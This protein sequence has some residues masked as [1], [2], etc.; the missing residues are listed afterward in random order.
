MAREVGLPVLDLAEAF[1]GQTTAEMWVHS[2]DHHPNGRAHAIASAA[3]SNWLQSND[4][5][6]LQLS[7][8][9]KP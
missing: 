5:E 4:S 9:G 2:C 7:V 3:I 6:L 8:D 1:A